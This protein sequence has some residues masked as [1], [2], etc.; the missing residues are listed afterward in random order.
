MTEEQAEKFAELTKGGLQVEFVAKKKPKGMIVK[1][2]KNGVTKV[3]FEMT[4][5]ELNDVIDKAAK[6]HY[7]QKNDARN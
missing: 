7:K 6:E 1:T 2:L 4:Q 3:I 5:E